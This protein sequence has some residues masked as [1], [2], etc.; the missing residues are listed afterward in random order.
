MAGADNFDE[1]VLTLIHNWAVLVEAFYYA[2]QFNQLRKR[3]SDQEIVLSL[4]IGWS[5]VHDLLRI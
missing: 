3:N 5:V 1:G 2:F 4:G